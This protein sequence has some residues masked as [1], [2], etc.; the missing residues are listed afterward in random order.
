[1]YDLIFNDYFTGNF[2]SGPKLFFNNLPSIQ[3]YTQWNEWVVQPNMVMVPHNSTRPLNWPC[4]FEEHLV[5]VLRALG[6][7]VK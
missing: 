7:P 2:A 4:F 5:N 6:S 3:Y 1:M